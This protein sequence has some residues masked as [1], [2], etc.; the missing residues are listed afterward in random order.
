MYDVNIQIQELNKGMYISDTL[1]G[2]LSRQQKTNTLWLVRTNKGI[3]KTRTHKLEKPIFLF[4]ITN[5]AAVRNSKTITKFNGDL[6]AIVA[7]KGRT[8]NYGS[9]FHDTA[10]LSKI[11]QYHEDMIK[12]INITQKSSRYHLGPIKEERRKKYLDTM[13]L[14]GNQKSS[15]SEMNSAALDKSIS[16]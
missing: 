1:K 14:N 15:H 9:E 2:K 10:D 11:F 5:E 4:K 7:Q 8:L 3:L 12:I 16:K 6:A 13:I